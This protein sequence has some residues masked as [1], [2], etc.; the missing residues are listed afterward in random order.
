M[1]GAWLTDSMVPRL[2]E[3]IEQVKN[4]QPSRPDQPDRP[5]MTARAALGGERV[6]EDIRLGNC[7]R[8]SIGVS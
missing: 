7:A 4:G 2:D 8:F 5:R 1:C 3:D 6:F